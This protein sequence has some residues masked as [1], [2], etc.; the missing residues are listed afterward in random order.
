MLPLDQAQKPCAEIGKIIRSKA[1]QNVLAAGN[2]IAR[3]IR[4]ET[5]E[6]KKVYLEI[7]NSLPTHVTA[8]VVGQASRMW[9]PQLSVRSSITLASVAN[10][11]YARRVKIVKVAATPASQAKVK[12][13]RNANSIHTNMYMQ[14]CLGVFK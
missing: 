11:I 2:T 12:M 10:E 7:Y 5:V 6:H 9:M 8:T 14:V 13:S 3:D 1:Q 4:I